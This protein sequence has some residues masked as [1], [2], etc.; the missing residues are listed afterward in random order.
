MRFPREVLIQN[1]S[2]K[3]GS[4][5]PSTS[6]SVSEKNSKGQGDK[7]SGVKVAVEA[8]CTMLSCGS[9]EEFEAGIEFF[10]L[11]NVVLGAHLYKRAF[12]MGVERFQI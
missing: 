11:G 10:R 7:Q 2:K 8:R 4:T 1:Q 12:V 5:F 9:Q 3:N 6:T